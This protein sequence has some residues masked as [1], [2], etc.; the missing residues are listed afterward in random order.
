MQEPK[1]PS[2][3]ATNRT[4]ETL[5]FKVFGDGEWFEL[6]LALLPGRTAPILTGSQ[7]LNPSRVSVDG[8]TVGEVVA[9]APDGHEIAR[10]PPPW[11][12]GDHWDIVETPGA[13]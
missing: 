9:V 10:H 11:C 5:H 8:C 2:V 3:T 12:D 4:S 1:S 7:L 6:S 13:S